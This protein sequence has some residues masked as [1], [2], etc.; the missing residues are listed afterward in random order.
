MVKCSCHCWPHHQPA[1]VNLWPG[2]G[3]VFWTSSFGLRDSPAPWP[4]GGS[5]PVFTPVITPRT[6]M[7]PWPGEFLP[8]FFARCC[9]FSAPSDRP[10]SGSWQVP[11]LVP[12][13]GAGLQHRQDGPGCCGR[14]QAPSGQ[15]SHQLDGQRVRHSH[16][17]CPTT[18]APFILGS[19][20][21][22]LKEAVAG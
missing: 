19:S 1:E 13:D 8:T 16:Q 3:E 18:L 10:A 9:R 17:R 22:L 12:T 2:G 4:P 5:L 15:L 6:K 11:V 21:L 20:L 14:A 7:C